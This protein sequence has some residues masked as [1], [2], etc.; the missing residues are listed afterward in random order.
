MILICPKCRDALSQIDKEQENTN[1]FGMIEFVTEISLRY[2]YLCRNP[3]WVPKPKNEQ[4][5]FKTAW[6]YLRQHLSPKP[7]E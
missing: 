1:F 5:I 3:S 6:K 4:N 2:C 7:L